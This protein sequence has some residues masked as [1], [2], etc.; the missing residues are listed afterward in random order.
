MH[1]IQQQAK[2]RITTSEFSAK[3][4]SKIE[5]YSFLAIDVGAY[6]PP[7]ECVT[8]YF[9]KDLANSKKKCEST[10]FFLVFA[11]AFLLA[12]IPSTS[13]LTHSNLGSC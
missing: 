4:R 11:S 3:F 9:L 12:A 13:I 6:L 5:V 8:I 1:A 2:V 10:P 7:H